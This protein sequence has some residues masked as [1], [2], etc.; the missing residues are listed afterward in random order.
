MN[1]VPP[2]TVLSPSLFTA[3]TSSKLKRSGSTFDTTSDRT[4]R[5][6][7]SHYDF[8]SLSLSS[9]DTVVGPFQSIVHSPSFELLPPP[10]LPPPSSL[11]HLPPL[12]ST[13]SL[14]VT[15]PL[16]QGSL[17]LAGELPTARDVKMHSSYLVSPHVVHVTSLD[18]DSDDDDVPA[19]SPDQPPHL[20][21]SASGEGRNSL[22]PAILL[23][24]K[25]LPLLPPSL[26]PS[27]LPPEI[28]QT[29]LGASTQ[30]R[31]GGESER[32]LILYQPNPLLKT[33]EDHHQRR[34]TTPANTRMTVE[35]MAIDDRQMGS[36][37]ERILEEEEEED[38]AGEAM[39]L[40]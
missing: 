4:K 30:I 40:D 25:P 39:D 14:P 10:P 11:H 38:A 19:L 6:R 3:T 33:L 34:E 35:L 27:P 12:P 28:L 20:Q 15:P 8:A 18:S 17:H 1:P 5:S 21:S 37:N 26:P 7:L 36:V 22:S 16:Q 9:P 29:L 2:P 31:N 32:G 24:D 13:T 23:L